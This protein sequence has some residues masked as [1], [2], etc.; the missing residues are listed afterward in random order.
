MLRQYGQRVN[1]NGTATLLM[2]DSLSIFKGPAFAGPVLRKLHGPVSHTGPR[3]TGGNDMSDKSRSGL[4]LAF[5]NDGQSEKAKA[6]LGASG[7]AVDELIT[8]E[9]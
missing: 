9:S 4:G 6:E 5:F 8:K 1:G 7:Q 2:A 3:S